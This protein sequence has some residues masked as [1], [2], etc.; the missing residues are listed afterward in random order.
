MRGLPNK[1][2]SFQLLA[3][4][5]PLVDKDFPR[6]QNA[7]M[8]SAEIKSSVNNLVKHNLNIAEGVLSLLKKQVTITQECSMNFMQIKHTEALFEYLQSAL[9][10]LNLCVSESSLNE[11]CKLNELSNIKKL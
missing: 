4:V 6:A 2:M 8:N 5:F 11:I 7:A 3:S 10:A 9:S 1:N